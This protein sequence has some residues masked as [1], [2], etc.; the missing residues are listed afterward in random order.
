MNANNSQFYRIKR[1]PPYVFAVVNEQKARD[2][3]RGRD[4]IDLGMGNPDTPVSPHIVDKLKETLSNP[5]VHGYSMS[6]GIKGLRKAQCGYYARRFGVELDP[7]KE[8][9]VTIGSKEGLA[10]LLSAITGPGDVVMVPNPSYPIH[11]YGS[12]I[13]GGSVWHLPNTPNHNF[14]DQLNRAIQHCQPKPIALIVNYPCNPT[15]EVVSLEFYEQV[16]DVCRHHGIWLISD[17]AYCEI[18][19][20]ETPPPSILQV[21]GAKD[22]AIEFTSMSKTYSMA[23]W[24]IGFAAGNPTLIAAL[25]RI[26]SYL[27][28]GSFT[29]MQ[30]AA[31]TAINGSQQCVA[32]LRTMYK[33]RRD[34]LVEGLHQA[35][36]KVQSPEASMFIWAELPEAY[37][38]IGSLAFSQL[39]IEHAEVAVAPGIGFGEY[40]DTHVRIAMVENKQRLRQAVRNIKH[41]LAQDPQEIIKGLGA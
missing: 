27:D 38:H 17:L 13:A 2:R 19:F 21:A 22:I 8:M 30:V 26:K 23:G 18:Y 39:M 25:T 9:V 11:P 33:E 14:F 34:I 3:A 29:P 12:L 1:L 7:E 20:G 41:F 36:W 15:A 4:I 32:E 35:G 24:R 40:G 37:R 28:Y 5:R 16:V 6:K 31:T 10:N